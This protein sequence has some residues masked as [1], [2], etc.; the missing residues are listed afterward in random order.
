MSK[1]KPQSIGLP[2]RT[3]IGPTL[4]RGQD[5]AVFDMV[6]HAEKAHRRPSSGK[7]LKVN[8]ASAGEHRVRYA[9]DR[10]A[11]MAGLLYKKNKY[12]ILKR[13]LGDFVPTSSFVLSQVTEGRNTRYAE[14]TVQEKVPRLSLSD[15]TPE[16]AQSP[17]LRQQVIE[18]MARLRNMYQVIGEANA[19][20]SSGISL[21]GKLDLGGVS[22]YVRAESFDHEFDESDAESIINS[23]K[24]PNL[25]VNPEDMSL[26]CI[27]F[28]QGQWKP[29]M[30]EAK[31]LVFDIANRQNSTARIVGNAAL[32]G[33]D[34]PQLPFS[35]GV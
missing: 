22:D 11:A 24:S 14:L 17:I 25:L 10:Q 26:Y 3:E 1:S 27:D 20:T 15:L 23:N 21:D 5:N 16:Q 35:S 19:R 33:H 30:D 34:D 13:F 29:G 4:G 6:F 12:E 8:H 32:Q 7:V 31:N 9:D 18:L 28:D 2:F